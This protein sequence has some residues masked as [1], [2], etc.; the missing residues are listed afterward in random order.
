MIIILRI[1]IILRVAKKTNPTYKMD[2]FAWSSN[3]IIHTYIYIYIMYGS[4]VA[5][6]WEPCLRLSKAFSKKFGPPWGGLTSKKRICVRGVNTSKKNNAWEPLEPTIR[7]RIRDFLNIF[8][9]YRGTLVSYFYVPLIKFLFKYF[10]VSRGSYK[11]YVFEVL[12]SLTDIIFL[13]VDSIWTA[14]C[15]VPFYIYIYI[16]I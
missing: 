3:S 16:Y 13:L 1:I 8:L 15:V 5:A 14:S 11:L 12:T 10:V 9:S 4:S 6:C 7:I 2:G